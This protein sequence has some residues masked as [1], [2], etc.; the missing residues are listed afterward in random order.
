M[1]F[2]DSNVLVYA[3]DARDA[4]KQ[5][6]AKAIVMSARDSAEYVISAQVLNEFSNVAMRK[7]GKTRIEVVGF[8]ELFKAVRSIPVRSEWTLLALEIMGRYDLKFYDALLLAAA[9][10]HGCD[11]FL[12]EDLGDGQ[13][14]CGIKVT[15]PFI[16]H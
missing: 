9:K 3:V 10:E 7:L 4:G 14:Y 11:R 8:V 13:I 15:N 1:T 2:L 12:S 16:A 6:I 5:K